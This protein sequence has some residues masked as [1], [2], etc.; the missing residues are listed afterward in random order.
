M[1]REKEVLKV[2]SHP[3]YRPNCFEQTFVHVQ[4]ISILI[5]GFPQ[6]PQQHH[7]HSVER[8]HT[9]L[10]SNLSLHSSS[11]EDHLKRYQ[12]LKLKPKLIYVAYES[13]ACIRQLCYYKVIGRGS[14][15]FRSQ[16]SFSFTSFSTTE[17]EKHSIL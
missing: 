13:M 11:R 16:F 15:I 7:I 17:N 2:F 6:F 4:R 12:G 14:T 9:R 5:M 3:N 10:L 1:C 8:T